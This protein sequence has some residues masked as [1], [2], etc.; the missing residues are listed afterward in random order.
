MLYDSMIFWGWYH[1]YIWRHSWRHSESA[2]LFSSV[3]EEILSISD[4]YSFFPQVQTNQYWLPTELSFMTALEAWLSYTWAPRR[5]EA[6]LSLSLSLKDLPLD[7][8]HMERE[9]SFWIPFLS[10]SLLLRP[11]PFSY[12]KFTKSLKAGRAQII[13]LQTKV[14]HSTR[15]D[16]FPFSISICKLSF[17]S[18]KFFL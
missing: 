12:S 9:G 17:S 5:L 18:F 7:W 4:L 10:S 11:V 14:F 8:R 3:Y 16:E 15:A 1:C 2:F 6:F 13:L